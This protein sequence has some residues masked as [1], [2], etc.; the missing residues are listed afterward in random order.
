MNGRRTGRRLRIGVVVAMVGLGLSATAC[1]GSDQ[2]GSPAH[3]V[4]VWMTGSGSGSAIGALQ[5]AFVSVDEALAQHQPSGV[6]RTVCAA[7]AQAAEA[8]NTDLPT[9]DQTLTTTLSDAYAAALSAGTDCYD[10]AAGNAALLSRS[11]AERAR[12]AELLSAAI[13]RVV[14]LT[15]KVPSTTTTTNPNA[16]SGDPFAPS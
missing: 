13:S 4:E 15:G 10:G 16:G 11:A 2:L 1:A 3:R 14:Q 6:V 5:A 8:A 12:S 9:P 7:L